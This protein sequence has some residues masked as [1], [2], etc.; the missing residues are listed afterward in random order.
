MVMTCQNEEPPLSPEAGA[1][2]ALS[3]LAA[4]PLNGGSLK[5]WLER[6]FHDLTHRIAR[7]CIHHL[8][9]FGHF[10]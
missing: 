7:Q 9:L 10:V 2:E 5:Q 3:Q 6:G 4:E 1:L 8:K